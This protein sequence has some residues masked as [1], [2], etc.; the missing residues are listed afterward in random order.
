[1]Q[2]LSWNKNLKVENR[3]YARMNMF[4][5]RKIWS[6][7]NLDQKADQIEVGLQLY[8]KVKQTEHQPKSVDVKVS[9]PW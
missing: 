4:Q 1:M 3:K 9:T 8:S 5:I 2:I 6:S 7:G